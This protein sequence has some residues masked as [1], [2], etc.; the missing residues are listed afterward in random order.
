MDLKSKADAVANKVMS[1]FTRSAVSTILEQEFKEIAGKGACSCDDKIKQLKAAVQ[2]NHDW[3]QQYDE[4][5]GYEDS[6]LCE[7]NYEALKL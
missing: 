5:G 3:H 6:L 4:Y 1:F 7:M 2:A